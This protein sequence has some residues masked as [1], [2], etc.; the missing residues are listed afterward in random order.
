M[1]PMLCARGLS[2]TFAGQRVLDNVDLDIDPGEIRA[3]VGQNGCGK[4]T[5][6]KILAGFYDPDHGGAVQ[7]GG[8][9]LAL[10]RVGAGD[11]VGIRFVHQDLGLVPTLDTVDNLALGHGYRHVSAG[12]IRWRAEIAAARKA[13]SSLGYDVDVRRPVAELSISERTAVAVARAISDFRAQAR[14]LVLDEP[15]AN[16]PVSEAR[17]L[18][19]LVRTVAESGIAVLFV[20]HHLEEVFEV[21]DTVSVLRDGKHVH[22]G[23]TKELDEERLVQLMIGRTIDEPLR[24]NV[25]IGP[26]ESLLRVAGLA[27]GALVSLDLDVRPGEVVGI[28]GITGSGREAVAMGLF[29]GA[30]RTGTVAVDSVVLPAGRPDRAMAAG[31]G[32]VPAERHLNA[33]LLHFSLRENVTV[34]DPG[35]SYVGGL[36]RRRREK[37]DVLTWLDKLQVK[38]AKTDAI[39]ATLSGGNQQKVV[40]AR[41]LRMA[42]R[43]LVLDEP[44]QG[45]DVGAKAEIHALVDQAA[46]SG[47]AVL[48]MSTDSGE[49]ARLCSRV[50]VLRAGVVAEQLIGDDVNADA[51]TAATLGSKRLGATA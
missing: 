5:F 21:A 39:M 20:S 22:T 32:L 42:P 50:L 44:T 47:A 31:M 7:I 51:I 19:A 27:T 43:V 48:V 1:S 41:W 23:P 45:V 18:F 14:V 12:R 36:L 16:L 35:R 13:L 11:H 30:E 10:G 24:D 46:G 37:S 49:L 6:I 40:L 33:A 29:G 15:T 2:M 25:P 4:S 9:E 28:G 8:D 38:P 3:L 34:T 26:G 17:R